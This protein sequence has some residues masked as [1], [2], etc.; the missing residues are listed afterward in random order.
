MRAVHVTRPFVLMLD[1]ATGRKVAVGQPVAPIRIVHKAG[2]GAVCVCISSEQ[3]TQNSVWGGG[4]WCAGHSE[5][6]L[7]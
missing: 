3:M 2:N 5:E 7:G 1:E 4:G 6:H